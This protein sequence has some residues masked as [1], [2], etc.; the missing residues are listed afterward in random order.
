MAYG[1]MPAFVCQGQGRTW[2]KTK[3]AEDIAHV[4]GQGFQ[5]RRARGNN[6]GN[7]DVDDGGDGNGMM[8]ATERA[9]AANC[10]VDS[11]SHHLFAVIFY[12]GNPYTIQKLLFCSLCGLSTFCDWCNIQR[13]MF[14]TI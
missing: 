2:L 1:V 14:F 9:T 12:L 10:N 5:R 4:R 6:D 8:K 3:F 11:L 13:V 7:V